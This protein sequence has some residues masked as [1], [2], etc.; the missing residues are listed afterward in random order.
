MN[1]TVSVCLL[2]VYACLLNAELNLMYF[3]TGMDGTLSMVMCYF[4]K[5]NTKGKI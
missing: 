1:L 4:N 5:N 2:R 3:D